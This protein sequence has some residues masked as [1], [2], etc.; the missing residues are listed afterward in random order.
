[1]PVT[2]KKK[3]NKNF[4]KLSTLCISFSTTFHFYLNIQHNPLDF[5]S[6]IFFLK[7]CI[8]IFEDRFKYS[9]I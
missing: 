5:S 6:N 7:I 2:K 8:W 1:M 3:G 4:G 9:K